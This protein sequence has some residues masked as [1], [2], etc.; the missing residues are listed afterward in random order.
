MLEIL[1]IAFL[2]CYCLYGFFV[3]RVLSRDIKVSGL[4]CRDRRLLARD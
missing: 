1:F 4:S 2:V 3:G